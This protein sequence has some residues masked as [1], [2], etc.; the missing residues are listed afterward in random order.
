MILPDFIASYGLVL[1]LPLA[2]IEGPVVAIL[3]GVLAAKGYFGWCP[4]VA[5]LLLGDLI[6]D[7]LYYWF[8]RTGAAPLAGLAHRLGIERS[9]PPALQRDLASNATHMWLIGKWTH[10]LGFVVLVGSGMLRLPLGRFLAINL[11]ASLPKIGLLFGLGY[12]TAGQYRFFE[13]HAGVTVALLAVAG[14]VA[15]TLVLRRP[16]VAGHADP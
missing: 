2:I 8:G 3:S 10:S 13:R 16:R 14:A 11:L 7:V 4:A 5:L 15:I 1:L 9:V 12:F 6:G